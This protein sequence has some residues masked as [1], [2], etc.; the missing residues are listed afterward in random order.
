[1]PHDRE[2]LGSNPAGC[3]ALYLLYLISSG[4]LI[5][6]V[7]EVQHNLI[8]IKN[9]PICAAWGEASSKAKFVSMKQRLE[10]ITLA[11]C[12]TPA[13]Y[14]FRKSGDEGFDDLYI[15]GSLSSAALRRRRRRQRQ[16]PNAVDAEKVS[17]VFF[18][19]FILAL[20]VSV[21]RDEFDVRKRELWR[22][23][24]LLWE[25]FDD[26]GDVASLVPDVHHRKPVFERNDGKTKVRDRFL[27][28][29]KIT[30]KEGNQGGWIA[31]LLLTRQ[32]SPKNF[33][34]KIIDIAEVNQLGWLEESGHGL[35]MLIEPF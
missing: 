2:V 32:H 3:C 4:S 25:G 19:V 10:E 14:L 34:G 30:I 8:S 9:M 22:R 17:V 1:M 28:F 18:V 20:H 7:M 31:H 5:R 29:K 12:Q 35:K 27:E 26:A 24:G 11:G 21:V 33:R 13:S 15:A 6:S 23:V 16:R